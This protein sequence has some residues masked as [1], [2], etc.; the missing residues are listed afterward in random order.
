MIQRGSAISPVNGL[1]WGLDARISLEGLLL[2]SKILPIGRGNKGR[3]KDKRMDYINILSAFDIETTSLSEIK[4]SFM[5]IWQ[6]YF[7]SLESGADVLIYGRTWDEWQECIDLIRETLRENSYLV[8]LDHNLSYE[9]AFFCEYYSFRPDEVFCTDPR[10]VVKCSMYNHLEYR[11]TMRHSNTSLS[12]YTKQWNVQHQKL[13]GEEYDYNK[14]RYP[15]SELTDEELLYA[16][17]DVIGLCEAYI[18][19]MKYWGDDLYSVPMTSTGYVRRICKRAWATVSYPDRRSW[20]PDLELIRLLEE[21][22][23]GGDTHGSRFHSTPESVPSAV[24]INNVRSYD[25]SSS[26][27]DVLVNCKFPLGD[28]Y[29][30]RTNH[31]W[32]ERE[33]IEKIII[34]YEKAVCMRVHFKGLR[35]A[36]DGW[37][38]PYIPKSK[39]GFYDDIVEDNGR[40]LSAGLLSMTI[41]EVDWEI[42]KREYIWDKVFFSDVWYCRKRFLPDPFVEV[43]RQF[44]RDKTYLKSYEPG[45]LEE[46]EYNLKKQL[47]NSLYGMAAQHVIKTDVVF[48]AEENRYI[49]GIDYQIMLVEAEQNREFSAAEKNSFRREKES[50]IVE[51]H[52][53][54]AFLPFS[55]GVWC[56]AWARLELHRSMWLVRKQGGRNVYVDT[57]SNKH[58][59]DIDFSALNEYYKN[60]SIE[61]GAYADDKNG[62][63]YY[64]GVYDYEY[65]AGKFAH[66]GAKKYIYL[67]EPDPK[68]KTIAERH[69]FHLTVAG[70]NKKKGADELWKKGGFSA[71]HSGTIFADS[72]GVQGVYNDIPYGTIEVDG[73]SLYIGKNVCLLPDTYTL[74]LSDDYA[75]LLDYLLVYG[76]IDGETLGGGEE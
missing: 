57:D 2:E 23:R 65:T 20:M 47:L 30:L 56:T 53:K 32:I 49:D 74:G 7:I 5:Y 50:E 26:Y 42:L 71:W 63:R 52:N 43:V 11:C 14:I 28:W 19:E 61:R 12:V 35:L 44:F 58:T 33:E 21:A 75:K 15:W 24:I 6:W 4:Q 8:V 72:G 51:R 27:P 34:K 69:G 17:H 45:T 10:N 36:W 39:C 25:R 73:H 1:R 54:N 67:T 76:K 64:M 40:I 38:M 3:R 22:F 31:D 16:F 41:T 37:E 29:K 46:T 68:G 13:S 48:L 9:F 66:M 55:I 60:R 18:A 62:K 59:G 70:V